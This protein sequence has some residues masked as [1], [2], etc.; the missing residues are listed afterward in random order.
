MHSFTNCKADFVSAPEPINRQVIGIKTAT[1]THI[2][3]L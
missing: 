1:A 2:G 3:T